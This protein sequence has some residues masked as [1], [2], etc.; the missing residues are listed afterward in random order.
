MAM[1]GEREGWDPLSE[2]RKQNPNPGFETKTPSIEAFTALFFSQL[3]QFPE[4]I[5]QNPNV[6]QGL[7]TAKK[8]TDVDKSTTSVVLPPS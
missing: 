6:I 4:R 1:H 3:K 7:G 2:L 5:I 8:S